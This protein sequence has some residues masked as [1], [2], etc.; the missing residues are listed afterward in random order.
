[1]ASADEEDDD[2]ISVAPFLVGTGLTLAILAVL[3]GVLG[4]QHPM[5]DSLAVV[6]PLAI[7]AVLVLA[8]PPRYWA[9]RSRP[10]GRSS[11]PSSRAARCSLPPSSPVARAA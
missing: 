10:S 8:T 11:L 2:D 4:W 7:G 5:G 9:F 3:G 6:R 1:V